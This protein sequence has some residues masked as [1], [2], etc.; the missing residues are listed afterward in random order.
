M[1]P[2][3]IAST[4]RRRASSY[5]RNCEF[6]DAPWPVATASLLQDF[7]RLEAT[8][9]PEEVNQPLFALIR[10]RKAL[11]DARLHCRWAS[12]Q[13][14]ANAPLQERL[15]AISSAL[16]NAIE[17]FPLSILGQP[18]AKRR[19]KILVDNPPSQS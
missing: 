19:S 5:T 10:A 6:Q 18:L 3:A 7:E 4:T 8:H 13:H 14:P 1:D 16:A 2:A 15:A 12:K 11:G 17:C 9:S